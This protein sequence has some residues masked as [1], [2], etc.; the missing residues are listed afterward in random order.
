MT[1]QKP[2]VQTNAVPMDDEL[3]DL[4][5]QKVKLVRLGQVRNLADAKKKADEMGCKLLGTQA[6]VPFMKKFPES[7]SKGSIVFGSSRWWRRL[8]GRGHPYVDYL[9]GLSLQSGRTCWLLRFRN[10][11]GSFN[12]RFRWLVVAK[13]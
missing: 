4:G 1:S 10:W 13:D 11:D 5:S 8:F 7:D 3:F 6:R 12:E 9:S 2:Q